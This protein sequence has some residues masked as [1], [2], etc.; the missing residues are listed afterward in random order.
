MSTDEAWTATAR[1]VRERHVARA[2]AV[3][4]IRAAVQP[5]V[6]AIT[7]NQGFIQI[8]YCQS[9]CVASSPVHRPAVYRES[10]ARGRVIQRADCPMVEI[11]TQ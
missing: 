1:H 9:Q 6:I 8:K 2:A 10:G 11:Q 5:S 7:G 3:F 4:E